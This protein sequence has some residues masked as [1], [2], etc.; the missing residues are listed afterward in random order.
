MIYY[1]EIEVGGKVD[2]GRGD[3]EKNFRAIYDEASA[4][5]AS[6]YPVWQFQFNRVEQGNRSTNPPT[7]DWYELERLR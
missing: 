2:L 4:F 1:A 5:A 7:G 3:W 6:Q